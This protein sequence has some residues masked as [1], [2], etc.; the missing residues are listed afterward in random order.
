[1]KILTCIPYF[2]SHNTIKFTL[3]SIE[4]QILKPNL[5][6]VID[7]GSELDSIDFL[8][9]IIP[10]FS[11]KIEIF[12]FE[13]NIGIGNLRRY[14]IKKV[15]SKYQ[16]EY[17]HSLDSDDAIHPMFYEIMANIPIEKNRNTLVSS[18]HVRF[19]KEDSIDFNC[20]LRSTYKLKS[21]QWYN[22]GTPSKY[23]LHLKNTNL[24]INENLLYRIPSYEDWIFGALLFKNKFIFKKIDL[25]ICFY[26]HQLKY[27]SSRSNR[28][29]GYQTIKKIASL[30]NN[31]SGFS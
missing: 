7:D 29:V 18:K 20:K 4:N 10:I 21:I 13:K 12:H 22:A 15:V 8:K 31:V 17:F 28:F 23:I 5:V 26:R 9:S 11:F 19:S 16:C 25:P 24:S 3:K 27:G 1:M 6:L 14:V 2:N 30:I